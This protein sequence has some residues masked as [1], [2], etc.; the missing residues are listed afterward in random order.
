MRQLAIRRARLEPLASSFSGLERMFNG[1]AAACG[2][3]K[4]DFSGGIA[5]F[6]DILI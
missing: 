5:P 4:I 6:G 1:W 3:G 2:E